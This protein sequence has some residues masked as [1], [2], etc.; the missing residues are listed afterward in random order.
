MMLSEKNSEALENFSGK[1]EV[2]GR[3]VWED[4]RRRFM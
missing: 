1:L 3:R 2:G 4:A